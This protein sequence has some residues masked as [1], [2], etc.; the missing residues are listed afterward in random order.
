MH[1]FQDWVLA[2]V[3]RSIKFRKTHLEF[4]RAPGPVY[5]LALMA[6]KD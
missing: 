6:N 4:V 3:E 2:D 1:H 5:V